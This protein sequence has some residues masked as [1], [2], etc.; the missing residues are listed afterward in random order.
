MMSLETVVQAAL[1]FS[2]LARHGF[3]LAPTT[4]ETAACTQYK[5]HLGRYL[6]E[7]SSNAVPCDR[8]MNV[9]LDNWKRD[10]GVS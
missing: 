6:V 8:T 3:D 4:A 10:V 9:Q 7:I 2:S 5:L 1:H